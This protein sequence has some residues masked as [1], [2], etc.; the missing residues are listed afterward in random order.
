MLSLTPFLMAR[1]LDR[2]GIDP[3]NINTTTTDPLIIAMSR[4]YCKVGTCPTSWQVIDYRPSLAGNA[5][6]MTIYILL[7][8][9]Q[10]YL[11]VRH[12]TW[13]YT[14]LLVT[15]LL[16]EMVGYAGRLMLNANPFLMNNFLVNLI[17]LTLAPA[18]F[19]A[20][21]YLSLS[22]V[23]F[24][25][26]PS[27][28][29]SRLKPRLYTYVFVGCDLLALVLQA[30]GGALAATAKDK[31]GSDQGVRVMIAGLV[32]QVVTMALFLGLWA[33]FAVR[34]K[35]ARGRMTGRLG[36]YEVLEASSVFKWFQ[37][38]LFVATVLIF[39]RCIYRVAEL[40]EG[41]GG[42]LANHEASFMVFEGPM[43][44]IA[45]AG[46]TWFHPGRV[47]GNLW[48]PAGRG[49]RTSGGKVG[50]DGSEVSLAANYAYEGV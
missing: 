44:I 3:N 2:N 20:A 13:K 50:N 15:G 27:N 36:M 25:L 29:Y 31:R 28:A 41:F 49:E 38:S 6:Y 23:L 47:F 12:K 16:G 9:A 46:L 8:L 37:W 45:V 5:I 4:K 48:G 43:V 39:V 34:M 18:L 26:D 21:I 11:G 10:G 14:A 22:R 24:I 7:L 19:T 33:D 17:P 32:S 1:A 30:I 40:W 35:R 42:H